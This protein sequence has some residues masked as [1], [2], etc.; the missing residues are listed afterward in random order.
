MEWGEE[1]P[2]GWDKEAEFGAFGSRGRVVRYVVVD[3]VFDVVEDF[4][5]ASVRLLLHF[6]EEGEVGDGGS[7]LGVEDEG[8]GEEAFDEFDK[9]VAAVGLGRVRR[10]GVDG[11]GEGELA[12]RAYSTR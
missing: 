4:A 5:V 3:E 12:L 2:D 6:G 7:G 10:W 9:C 11:E 8:D 1:A